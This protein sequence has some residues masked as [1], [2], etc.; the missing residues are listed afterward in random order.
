MSDICYVSKLFTKNDIN[1][2]YVKNISYSPIS[3][4]SYLKSDDIDIS[5]LNIKNNDELVYNVIGFYNDF[6]DKLFKV[7][8][9][10]ESIQKIIEINLEEKVKLKLDDKNIFKFKYDNFINEKQFLYFYF[11]NAIYLNIYLTEL[12][13]ESKEITYSPYYDNLDAYII[14]SGIY[15]LEFYPSYYQEYKN[16]GSFMA[17]LYG[18]IDIIDLSKNSYTNRKKIR[19]DDFAIPDFVNRY[20]I[21]TNLTENKKV[22]FTYESNENS[23]YKENPFIVCNNNTNVCNE[24]IESYYFEKGNKYTIFINFIGAYPSYGNYYY[25]YPIFKFYDE[26]NSSKANIDSDSNSSVFIICGCAFGLIIFL[27][28]LFIIIRYF[29]NKYQS[30]YFIMKTNAISNEN[31]LSY[32]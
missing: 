31:L 16:E 13:G 10:K 4:S 22:I 23:Y 1:S 6:T 5:E 3:G 26:A 19:I 30:N 32:M 9:P 27:I 18:L 28:V 2:I 7:Y 8:E 14:N 25:Y 12:N 24:N 29:K 20:Y 21:V 11:N 17:I 15:Y